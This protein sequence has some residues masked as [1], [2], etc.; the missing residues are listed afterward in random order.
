MQFSLFKSKLL[1][2]N[3]TSVIRANKYKNIG[4]SIKMQSPKLP[5][6][7]FQ[8]E[9]HGQDNTAPKPGEIYHL[10]TINSKLLALEGGYLKAFEREP[11]SAYYSM[12]VKDTMYHVFN[13]ARIVKKI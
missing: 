4:E 11:V 3:F 2:R 1:G 12:K 5:E 10:P 8:E 6:D 9:K 13:A 7:F